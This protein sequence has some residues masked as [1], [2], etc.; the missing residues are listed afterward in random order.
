MK[1][2]I[3]ALV[4]K[5]EKHGEVQAAKMGQEVARFLPQF[6]RGLDPRSRS[7][8]DDRLST[9]PALGGGNGPLSLAELT[10]ATDSDSGSFS[11]GLDELFARA[12]Q[13][14]GDETGA[15]PPGRGQSGAGTSVA[16]RRARCRALGA[17]DEDDPMNLAVASLARGKDMLRDGTASIGGNSGNAMSAANVPRESLFGNAAEVLQGA[18]GAPG[19]GAADRTP[20]SEAAD[21]RL[22]YFDEIARVLA[23]NHAASGSDAAA[24]SAL[25]N[26]QSALADASENLEA[27]KVRARRSSPE[28]IAPEDPLSEPEAASLGA[29]ALELERGGEGLKG[30]DLAGA[31]LSGADLAG[32]DLE[33]I[34]LEG[35]KLVETNLSGAKLANAVLTHADLTGSDLSGADLTD[36]NLSGANLARSRLREARLD[37]AQLF[38]SRFDGADLS[39]VSLS[40]TALIEATLVDVLLAGAV[41]RDVQFVKCVLSRV[42]LDEARLKNVV[43]VESDTTG[44][45]APGAHFERCALI[46]LQGEDADLTDAEFVGSTCIG[47][48]KLGRARMSGLVSRRSGWRGADLHEADLTAARFDESDLGE[49]NLTGACLHRASFRRAILHKANAA[50]ANFYGASLLEAQAREADFTRASLHSASLYSTDLTD[51]RLALCDLTAANLSL[52]LMRKPASAD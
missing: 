47:G 13:T 11:A 28:P 51:A 17:V 49:T 5:V 8:L 39:G 50:D 36:S 32:K 44:F 15:T 52:T 4:D 34:F 2:G 42:A 31:D 1:A 38:R 35:A 3:D 40:E 23:A 18:Q 14:L 19:A 20:G 48:A 25:E 21:P 7:L 41:V 45:R 9:V 27:A 43:L 37:R 10:E 46:G 33:G 16:W 22:A 29:L 30:R 24:E 6:A 12:G 26:A